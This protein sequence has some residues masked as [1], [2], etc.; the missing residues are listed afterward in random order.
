MTSP[1]WWT[2][3]WASSGSWWQTGKPGVLQ[4]MGLQT[5]GH[6]WATE[7]NWSLTKDVCILYTKTAA[8]LRVSRETW[9]CTVCGPEEPLCSPVEVKVLVTQS[10]LVLFD[11]VDCSPPGSSVL[12]ILQA[13]TLEWLSIPLS[14]WFSWPRDQTQVSCIAGGFF[15]VWATRIAPVHLWILLKLPY[16]LNSKFFCSTWPLIRTSLWNLKDLE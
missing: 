12:G 14:S 3:V 13:R 11:P 8:L 16:R 7:P 10:R 9:T 15:T 6:D 2:W 4:S 5:V 1:V